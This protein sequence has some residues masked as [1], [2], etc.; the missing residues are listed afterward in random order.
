MA[1]IRKTS[2]KDQVYDIIKEKILS[3]EYGLGD[4][5]NIKNL[6][7]ELEVSNTPVREAL[8][9]LEVEG[10][11][12]SDLNKKVKVI[13]LNEERK[14]ETD[15]FL[16]TLYAG[17]YHTCKMQRRI[18]MLISLM[19]KA[20]SDQKAASLADDPSAFTRAAISFDRSLVLATENQRLIEYHDQ[21]LPMLYL[22]TRYVHEHGGDNQQVN[23]KEHAAIL[24]A[25]RFGDDSAV[26]EKLYAHYDKQPYK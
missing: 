14:R 3:Q 12:V 4:S 20:L 9:R 25:V 15:F 22:L 11:V 26:M 7:D 21:F 16:Y 17:S 18:P 13:D 10:L 8:S 5:I 24:E 19:E 1:N 6:C 23:M 2:M